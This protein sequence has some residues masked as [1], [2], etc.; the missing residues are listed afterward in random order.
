MIT[1][2]EP[3]DRTDGRVVLA[4]L[5]SWAEAIAYRASFVVRPQPRARHAERRTNP[6]TCTLCGGPMRPDRRPPRDVR[7]PDGKIRRLPEEILVWHVCT[8]CRRSQVGVR[9]A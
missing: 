1:W 8:R 5:L 6:R 4:W 2:Q 3:T 9:A 7:Q